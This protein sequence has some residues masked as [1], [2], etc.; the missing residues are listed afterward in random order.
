MALDVLPR[1]DALTL[2]STVI[3]PAHAATDPELAEIAC[4]CGGLPLA[5]RIAGALLR[6][7]PTWTPRHLAALLRDEQ[8]RLVILTDGDHDLDAVFGLSYAGLEDEQ[9][10]LFRRLALVPGPDIDAHAAAA[11]LDASL[12]T[13][14]RLLENM[15]DH[16][17]LIQ[18]VP[19]RYQ[20]HDLIRAHARALA[21]GDPQPSRDAALDRLLRYYAHTAQAAS[22]LM[23]RYPR[24]APAGPAPGSAPLLDGPDAARTWLRAERENI[25]AAHA[26]ARNAAR[27]ADAVSLAAGVAEII[28]IDGP[29][30]QALEVHRA[31]A[32][33]AERH[34]W[35]DARATALNDLARVQRLAGDLAGATST[36]TEALR[37]HRFTGNQLGEADALTCLGHLWNMTGKRAEAASAVAEA[38]EIYRATGNRDGEASALT[39]LCG[40]LIPAGDL[41]GATDAVTQALLLCRATG[42]QSGE[43]DALTDLGSVAILTGDPAEVSNAATLA[44]RIYRTTGNRDGEA[45]A[46]ICLGH[47]QLMTRNPAEATD[48]AAQA[49][50]TYRAAGSRHGETI[51]LTLLGRALVAAGDPPGAV[52]VLAEALQML[53]ESG[54][55]DGEA[56]TLNFYA[57][58]IAAL[59][60]LPRALALYQQSLAM[61]RELRKHDDEAIALVGIG[62]CHLSAGDAEAG[63]AHLTQAL[64]IYDRLGMKA[65][66]ARVRTRLAPEQIQEQPC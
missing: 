52:G 57:A 54:S 15:L 31:A 14:T 21:V 23:A 56:W 65:D 24:S 8:Q 17:L 20:M 61:N 19:G 5:L 50:Q 47:G 49:L 59:G 48:Y 66:A 3:A 40:V 55:R 10:L 22:A 26:R 51:A 46:L 33:T 41:S 43:A 60:D 35:K 44:L 13:T 16:N 36:A 9:R 30:A 2:L 63:A 25:S 37:I 6:H 39:E 38:L 1:A 42:N 18:H 58:A 12:A 64:E 34:G 28:R 45:N 53:R 11:L 32:D 62:E 29:V 27:D 4:L 7:R